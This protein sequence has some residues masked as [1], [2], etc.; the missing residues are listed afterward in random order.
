MVIGVLIM[1]KRLVKQIIVAIIF[2][3][4]FVLI[5]FLIYYLAKPAPSCF[6]GIKNQNEE[7]IDCGGVCDPCELVNPEKISILWSETVL[8]QG[9]FYDVAVQVKNPN[10]NVGSGLIPYTLKLYSRDGS[11]AGERSGK[12]FILPNQVKYIVELKIESSDVVDDIQMSFGEIEWQS[13]DSF[14]QLAISQKEYTR[15]ENQAGNSQ[16]KGIIVNQGSISFSKVYIDILLF[17]DS[18]QLIGLNVVEVDDLPANQKRD[19]T[20]VWFEEMRQVASIETEAETNV[21]D[22]ENISGGTF[23]R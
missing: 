23:V 2:I 15:L 7:S 22:E 1:N 4:I 12:T 5:G 11:L 18:H 19:F 9:N 21:F 16:V 14:P 10:Q 6:D 17:D 20:A 8:T 3:A 13:T